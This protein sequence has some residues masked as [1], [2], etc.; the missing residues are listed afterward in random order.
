MLWTR[1]FIPVPGVSHVPNSP[2]NP[3]VTAYIALRRSLLKSNRSRYSPTEPRQRRTNASRSAG[4]TNCAAVSSMES[5]SCIHV[6][7]MSSRMAPISSSNASLART[8]SAEK[9][10]VS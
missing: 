9:N 10:R 7:A 5:G 6:G 8:S 1:K 2:E 4:R 3:S